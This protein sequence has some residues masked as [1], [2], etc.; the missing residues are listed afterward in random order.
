MVVKRTDKLD[1]ADYCI[2][3]IV[4]KRTI[5]AAILETDPPQ[6]VIDWMDCMVRGELVQSQLKFGELVSLDNVAS[7]A[8][9]VQK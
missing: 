1:E 4:D 6:V 9:M 2:T 7:R 5:A 3:V 8:T